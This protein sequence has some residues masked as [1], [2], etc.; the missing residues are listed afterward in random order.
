MA[1]TISTQ[2]VTKDSLFTS[3]P[4]FNTAPNS[5]L[6][7]FLVLVLVLSKVL[8]PILS[9]QI[10]V[11]RRLLWRT[12][13]SN[14]CQKVMVLRWEKSGTAMQLQQWPQLIP[15]GALELGWPFRIVSNWGKGLDLCIKG[16]LYLCMNQSLNMGCF[17]RDVTLGEATPFSQMQFLKKTATNIPGS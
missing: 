13:G 2:P 6:V 17:W 15:W 3:Q 4:S 10:Y 16:S 9:R 11:C 12:L 1:G 7:I 5:V 14:T 8:F